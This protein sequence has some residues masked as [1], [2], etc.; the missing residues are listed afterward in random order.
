[1][2]QKTYRVLPNPWK[3]A[4]MFITMQAWP[5]CEVKSVS[6][7]ETY[8]SHPSIVGWINEYITIHPQM[9]LPNARVRG[10]AFLSAK[11]TSHPDA[12]VVLAIRGKK[13]QD[14]ARNLVEVLSLLKEQEVIESYGSCAPLAYSVKPG[15]DASPYISALRDK[16]IPL[17]FS[18]LSKDQT[19]Y[20][21]ILGTLLLALDRSG[22]SIPANFAANN[23]SLARYVEG[24]RQMAQTDPALSAMARQINTW[25]LTDKD[26][27]RQMSL[28]A[29]ALRIM[30]A[31]PCIEAIQQE[32]AAGMAANTLIQTL[33]S[34]DHVVNRGYRI[35]LEESQGKQRVKRS[36]ASSPGVRS[37]TSDSR[38]MHVAAPCVSFRSGSARLIRS[39]PA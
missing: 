26:A 2:E 25:L 17:T 18:P 8:R 38:S 7:T 36:C 11:P 29:L 23:A 5:E 4:Q 28:T 39:V 21:Q 35:P 6:L 10:K 31:Q 32:Q 15:Q 3:R 22:N 24:C 27:A 13:P 33:D 19:V 20:Q 14:V 30:S 9:S 37:S 34:Y 16:G 1:M 12:P